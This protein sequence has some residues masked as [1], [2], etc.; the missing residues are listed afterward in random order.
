MFISL[1]CI[2]R[3]SSDSLINYCLPSN[4]RLF[5]TAEAVSLMCVSSRTVM[6]TDKDRS[7]ELSAA[8]T[9]TWRALEKTGKGP[10]YVMVPNV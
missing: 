8:R 5:D 3:S 10:C 1:M 6:T 9:P 4:A 2:S 7:S